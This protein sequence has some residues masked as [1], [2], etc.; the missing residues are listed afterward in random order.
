MFYSKKK[1][2]LLKYDFKENVFL[3]PIFSDCKIL[4]FLRLRISINIFQKNIKKVIVRLKMC[5]SFASA[6]GNMMLV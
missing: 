1:N 3:N 4:V 2:L 6:N 5:C